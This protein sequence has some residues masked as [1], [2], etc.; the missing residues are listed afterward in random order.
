M[1][2]MKQKIT[3]LLVGFLLTLGISSCIKDSAPELGSSGNTILKFNEGPRK[4]FYYLP[5]TGT[6][7]ATVTFSRDANSA[8]S[9][10]KPVEIVVL[11][12]ATLVPA[13]FTELPVANFTYTGSDAGIILTSGKIT[14]IRF[15]AGEFSK[16]IKLNL[17]GTA[18]TDLSVKYAKAYKITDVA[19][20]QLSAGQGGLV[21]T[22]AIKNIWDG[23]YEVTSG[24]FD[25]ITSGGTWS[26]INTFNAANGYPNSQYTL[27]TFNATKIAY[28]AATPF[29]G[30]QFGRTYLFNAGGGGSGY[31]SLSPIFEFDPVTNAVISV[32]NSYGQ[33]ASNTRSFELDP[34]GVNMYD[35]ATKTIQVKYRMLQ[36]SVVIA[37]PHIRTTIT[38]TLK[39]VGPTN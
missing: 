10:Q 3:V 36:P 22:F 27:K 5:F 13:G 29:S 12:D 6:Q 21:A 20:N 19:G 11:E 37:A 16:K 26:H 23:V 17:I 24:E 30:F 33:P 34:T 25:D 7:T 15:A 8:A 35:P 4:D 28:W 9:L 1:N 31:G 14:A 38:E 2:N 39:Y 18:W 32:T